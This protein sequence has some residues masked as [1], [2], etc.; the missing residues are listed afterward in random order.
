MKISSA[1]TIIFTYVT[2]K[3][4]L[5][6]LI[7]E[8]NKIMRRCGTVFKSHASKTLGVVDQ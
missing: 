7:S 8:K 2:A 1:S 4:R 3:N 5:N 6:N